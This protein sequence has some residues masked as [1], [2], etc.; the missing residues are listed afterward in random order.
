MGAAL[1]R[2]IRNA[3]WKNFI[4]SRQD[5][6]GMDA[7]IIS[8]KR[9]WEASGHVAGFADAMIDCKACKCVR[10]QITSLKTSLN[11]KTNPCL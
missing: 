3:W 9:I 8:H 5:M 6:V 11:P 4:E 7:S 10:A 1:L 2:N